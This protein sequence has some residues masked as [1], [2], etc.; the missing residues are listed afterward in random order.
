MGAVK[1]GVA[2]D[3]IV[4][5]GAKGDGVSWGRGFSRD[6]SVPCEAVMTGY[7]DLPMT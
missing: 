3:E 7:D 1:G 4:C 5:V 2:D 6:P